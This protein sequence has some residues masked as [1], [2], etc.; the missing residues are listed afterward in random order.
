[1]VLREREVLAALYLRQLRVLLEKSQLHLVGLLAAWQASPLHHA[2]LEAH[3]GGHLL[4]FPDRQGFAVAGHV[5]ERHVRRQQ[6]CSCLRCRVRTN[7]KH[8]TIK[9]SFMPNDHNL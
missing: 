8:I 3:E 1:M 9:L 2:L 5:L 6:S 4:L 7:L